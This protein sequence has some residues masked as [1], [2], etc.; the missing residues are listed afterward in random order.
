MITPGQIGTLLAQI[1]S[2]ED[3]AA[4]V[5]LLTLNASVIAELPPRERK[6]AYE[7]VTDAVCERRYLND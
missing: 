2:A 1:V 7:R 5:D 6:R 3:E 4:A